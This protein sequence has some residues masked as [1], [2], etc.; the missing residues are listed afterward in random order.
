MIEFEV[1]NEIHHNVG[2]ASYLPRRV[3]LV[4]V[5]VAIVNAC[6]TAPPQL[7][8]VPGLVESRSARS[9][10]MLAIFI[11]GDRG[12]HGLENDLASQ[13][14]Q[15]GISVIGLSAPA[16]FSRRRTPDEIAAAVEAIL[17][18]YSRAWSRDRFLLI[19][20]SRGA[21][22]MPF[23]VSRL[24][25]R[26]RS[27]IAEIVLIGLEA[28]IDFI[29]PDERPVPVQPEIEKLRGMNLLCVQG[30]TEDDSLCAALPRELAR[31]IVEP[32]GHVLTGDIRR[33]AKEIEAAADRER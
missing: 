19:G 27:R 28:D 18:T 12:W 16:Y 21:G 2:V 31:R 10:A 3:R 25:A 6:A 7:P 24:P 8:G 32:G 1:G 17:D 30:E 4:T 33:L 14:H 9:G 15:D 22:V 11:T 5:A 29:V 20:Y 13:F 26:L 23:V